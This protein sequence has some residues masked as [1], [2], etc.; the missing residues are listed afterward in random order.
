MP[1]ST[2]T[3][4][5]STRPATPRPSRPSS[6]RPPASWT[7]FI[8]GNAAEHAEF[9]ARL[10]TQP[11]GSRTLSTPAELAAEAAAAR[12]EYSEASV[13]ELRAAADTADYMADRVYG[14][15]VETDRDLKRIERTRH[16]AKILRAACRRLRELAVCKRKM[17]DNADTAIYVKLPPAETR[18]NG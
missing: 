12:A 15:S 5:P 11:D 17:P 16:R 18:E 6:R 8:H 4:S 14:R 1:C 13:S 7:L 2:I 9:E 10:H 3:T